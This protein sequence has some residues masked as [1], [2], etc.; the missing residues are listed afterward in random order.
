VADLD[1]P[2][3]LRIG[4][5]TLRWG[6]RTLVMGIVNATPDSFSG[7]GVLD[8]ARA[9]EQARA[10]VA[11]GADCIDIGAESTRPGHI[12]VDAAG[13]WARLE[14]VLRAVRAAVCVPITV[15]TAKAEVAALAFEAGADALNDV[16]GLRGDP[17]MASV[18]AASGKPAVLMHNQR[19][20]AASGDVIADIAAGLRESLALASAAGVEADRLILDPGFGFGW[21]PAENLEM[22]RRLGELRALGRPLLLGTSRKSTIG[23]VLGDR[24]EDGRLWGTAASV[25]LA[26][27]AG[28]D[29]VRVHDVSSMADVV[30]TADA[31]VR[32]WPSRERRVWLALG[33]NL[34]DRLG[35]LRA[36]LDALQAGSVAID[37]CSRVYETPPWGIEEQPRFA[38]AAVSARTS[39]SARELLA[40]CKRIERLA[41][42]DFGAPR[43]SARPIDLDILAIEGETLAE[44]DLMVPHAALQERAFV[45]LPLVDVAPGWRHPALRRTA[46]ELL[47]ALPHE[48]RAGI[49][50]LAEPGWWSPSAATP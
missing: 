18:L 50:V 15:D 8:A 7:D 14:P 40:L 19:G 31:A 36:A 43:N 13:E 49:E 26:V 46:T 35:Q 22:L 41:G 4:G 34:D 9:A 20:R 44:A 12:A 5:R 33:G 32:G 1:R 29:I 25:A 16:H 42:R 24:P 45:L 28:A 21:Q 38:N 39:L 6:E 17:A 37:L 3:P 23:A 27:E 47:A 2:A 10:M 48:A 30:R 11:A